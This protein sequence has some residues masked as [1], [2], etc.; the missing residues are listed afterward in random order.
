MNKQSSFDDRGA[1]GSGIYNRSAT[2]NQQTP[3]D[4]NDE[5]DMVKQM[6]K[7]ESTEGRDN[8]A[9]RRNLTQVLDNDYRPTKFND[10]SYDGG[11]YDEGPLGTDGSGKPKKGT[12]HTAKGSNMA[13]S[14]I[15]SG[16]QF[17]GNTKKMKNA[18]NLAQSVG[19]GLVRMARSR[20][21][22][23]CKM[24]GSWVHWLTMQTYLKSLTI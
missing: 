11:R 18:K 20:T 23:P 15:P 21:Q 5:P 8:Q 9:I 22:E 10:R 13:M 6:D 14:V 24:E 19:F 12:R 4:R 17:I 2:Y 1:D 7:I 16:G 3:F